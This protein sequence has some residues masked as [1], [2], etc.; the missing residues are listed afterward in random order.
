VARIDRAL[1]MVEA[2]GFRLIGC[3]PCTRAVAPGEP[4]RAGRWARLD[5][6][7]CGIHLSRRA[8]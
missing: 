7:E 8:S 3:A 1:P 4:Q 2:E 5:K 6:S